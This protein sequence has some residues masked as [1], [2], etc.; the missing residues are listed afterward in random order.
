MQGWDESN[1]MLQNTGA[2]PI[3]HSPSY[4]IGSLQKRPDIIIWHLSS[5]PEVVEYCQFA[6]IGSMTP[7]DI[8]DDY[9][10]LS[11]I[12]NRTRS[13]TIVHWSQIGI[14]CEKFHKHVDCLRPQQL[15][16]SWL[17]RLPGYSSNRTNMRL[18][19]PRLNTTQ[20]DCARKDSH[21]RGRT[22]SMFKTLWPCGRRW[23]CCT[24]VKIYVWS[25][26]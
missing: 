6:T 7:C 18:D 5:L 23:Q 26:A 1:K 16:R 25:W 9:S 13:A 15:I 20:H 12:W 2:R 3:H 24:Y 17:F 8:L 10:R 11:R 14:D 19:D 4:A 21:G 22:L